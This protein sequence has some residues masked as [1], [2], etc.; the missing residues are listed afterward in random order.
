RWL[1]QRG[2]RVRPTLRSGPPTRSVRYEVLG[3]HPAK[4]TCLQPTPYSPG[5]TNSPTEAGGSTQPIADGIDGEVN[6]EQYGYDPQQGMHVFDLA[7][8]DL[9]DD[10]G[11][12]SGT[13]SCGDRVRQRHEHDRQE[14]RDC[15]LNIGPIDIGDLLHH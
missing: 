13:D 12:E 2:R 10:I 11:D 1:R 15:D 8:G 3:L 7:A 5:D 6:H 14:R 4:S 9:E